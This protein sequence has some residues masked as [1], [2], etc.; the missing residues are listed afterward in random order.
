M[1]VNEFVE[2]TC[3]N[4]RLKDPL[5]LARIIMNNDKVPMHGPE[6]HFIVPAT[7]L[8]AY[9]NI[10]GILMKRGEKSRKREREQR[11]FLEVSAG[12]MAIAALLLEQAFS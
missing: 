3:I 2:E 12:S 11:I 9:Y 8:A 5:E 7:L 6:H 10:K 4:S 1:S